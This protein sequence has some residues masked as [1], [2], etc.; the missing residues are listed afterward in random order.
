M[1]A[2]TIM[3]SALRMLFAAMMRARGE[4]EVDGEERHADGSEGNQADLDPARGQALARKGACPDS[5]R[6][7]PEEQRHHALVAPE[8]LPGERRERGEEDRAEEP[9]PRN[10]EQ[11]VEYRAVTRR[12]AQVAPR[13]GER[14]PVD[15]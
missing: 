15:A 12:D 14:V 3:K 6:E 11:R 4:P 8:D 7:H 1:S 10:S 13:L 5:D 9:Q 2:A